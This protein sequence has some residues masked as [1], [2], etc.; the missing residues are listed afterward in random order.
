VPSEGDED[1]TNRAQPAEPAASEKS[2]RA[3]PAEPAASQEK[4]G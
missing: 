3:Q 4:E 2:N 1:Q